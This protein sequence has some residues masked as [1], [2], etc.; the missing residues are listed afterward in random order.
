[1]ERKEKEGMGGEGWEGKGGKVGEG[2]GRMGEERG[3]R[4]GLKG[5][6]EGKVRDPITLYSAKLSWCRSKQ[7]II[8]P[9]KKRWKRIESK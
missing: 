8:N 9:L 1:M 2:R 3:E 6:G 4:E 5:R 7:S